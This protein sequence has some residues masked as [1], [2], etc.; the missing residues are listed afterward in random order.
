[1]IPQ[2]AAS[3]WG[4]AVPHHIDYDDDYDNDNEPCSA[5]D[6]DNHVSSV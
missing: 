3:P 6:V 1:L 4:G 5:F 2:R